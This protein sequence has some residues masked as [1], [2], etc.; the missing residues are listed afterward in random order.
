MECNVSDACHIWTSSLLGLARM[1]FSECRLFTHLIAKKN[2]YHTPKM[3]F[4]AIY[5]TEFLPYIFPLP[6][7]NV[8]VC[9]PPPSPLNARQHRSDAIGMAEK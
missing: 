9:P 3:E 5:S 6:G 8:F 1:K 2:V 7:M 4:P